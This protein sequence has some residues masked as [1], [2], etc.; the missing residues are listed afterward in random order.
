MEWVEQSVWSYCDRMLSAKRNGNS[1]VYKTGETSL[2]ET[3]GMTKRQEAEL[4]VGELKM[5]SLKNIE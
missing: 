4:E 1:T 2:L 3:V 5:L